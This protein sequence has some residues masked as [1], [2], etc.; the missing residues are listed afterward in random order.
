VE[1]LVERLV[2]AEVQLRL[3]LFS[4]GFLK[5][6]LA[7]QVSLGEDQWARVLVSLGEDQWARVLVA[8][9]AWKVVDR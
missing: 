8:L 4:C 9:V 1:H 5:E 7:R 6:S 2:A 3:C